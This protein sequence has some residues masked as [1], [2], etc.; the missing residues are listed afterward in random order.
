M[1]D[2]PFGH[3]HKHGDCYATWYIKRKATRLAGKYG[4]DEDEGED[5]AQELGLQLIRQWPLYDEAKGKVTTFIQNVVDGR[6]CELLRDQRRAKRNHRRKIPL[7]KAGESA[8]HG[9]LDGLR[10]QPD[11]SDQDF[12]DLRV[13]CK[14]ILA[15]IPAELRTIAELL[16]DNCPEVVARELGI[17]RTT[18]WRRI[19]EIRAYFV[20]AGYGNT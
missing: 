11:V 6:I 20:A 5:I 19:T 10:G 1:S 7:S 15:L 8:E 3:K 16:K 4:F 2:S 18:L 17:S 9:K 12:V 13:D 14:G